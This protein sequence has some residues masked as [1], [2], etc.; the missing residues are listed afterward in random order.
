MIAPC[1]LDPSSVGRS[2]WCDDWI[3]APDPCKGI[4]QLW[5][6]SERQALATRCQVANACRSDKTR[7]MQASAVLVA[8]F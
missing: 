6:T 3:A 8:L 2:G 4:F 5:A 7:L 1:P